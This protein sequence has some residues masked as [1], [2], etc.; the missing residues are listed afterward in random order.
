MGLLRC[1]ARANHVRGTS[2][3]QVEVAARR[4][5]VALWSRGPAISLRDRCS[6]P[7]TPFPRDEAAAVAC[8]AWRCHAAASAPHAHMQENLPAARHHRQSCM[9]PL[10][11]SPQPLANLRSCSVCT[12][13]TLSRY[14]RASSTFSWRYGPASGAV[15]VTRICWWP[16]VMVD[17]PV[18][19]AGGGDGAGATGPGTG[20]GGAGAGG[21]G[22]GGALA[23]SIL[24]SVCAA[25]RS[26]TTCATSVNTAGA[27]CAS[28]LA[29]VSA[30]RARGAPTSRRRRRP[31]GQVVLLSEAAL[32]NVAV[33]HASST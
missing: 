11:V 1:T 33:A 17:M 4:Y 24:C 2:S 32:Q 6:W 21:A 7:C 31:N 12:P 13:L 22:A 10:S 20:A 28:R 8:H 23:G 14:A 15:C 5:R 27:R 26:S 25:A 9:C 18:V 19:A 29:G 30:Q 16:T 3:D